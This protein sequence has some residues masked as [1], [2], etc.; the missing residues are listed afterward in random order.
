MK[1][2]ERTTHAIDATGKSLGR[3]ASEA[4]KALMGKTTASYT[5]HIRSDV[6][7]AISNAAKVRLTEKKQLQKVY[8]RYS[9]FPGGLK[10]ESLGSLR[11]RSGVSAALRHAI[12]GMLPR[13]TL[14]VARM[15][16]LTITE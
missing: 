1:T 14:L 10:H 2:T 13:N 6:K 4:A 3:I 7:V 15:K 8:T 11:G 16:N 9:G 12:K 5:P